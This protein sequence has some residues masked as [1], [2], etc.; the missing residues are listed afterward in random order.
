MKVKI[1][2]LAKNP[3]QSGLAK[4]NLW[5][6]STIEESQTRSINDLT[7]W[8]SS[9]NTSTQLKIKFSS[10]DEAIKYAK[11]NNFDYVI[12]EARKSTVKPK[13]YSENF[14]STIIS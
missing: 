9:N 12:Y 5:L 13:S 10:K 7:G 8:T 3:M 6:V 14:P 1:T 4:S 11:Q 2:N